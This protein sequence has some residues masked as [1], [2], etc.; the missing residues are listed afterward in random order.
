M[1]RLILSLAILATIFPSCSKLNDGDSFTATSGGVQFRYEVIVSRMNF[2]RV[3]PAVNPSSL[4]GK[5]TIPSKVDYDGTT[6]AVTQV[7]SRAFEGAALITAITLPSGLSVIEDHAFSGCSSLTEINTPQPLSVIGEYA[8]EG[9]ANL[10]SF[11]FEA[12]LS[13]IGRG[14]FK[15]CASLTSLNLTSSFTSIADE[16][17]FGCASLK[18][19]ELPATIMQIGADAF[20]ECR[21]LQDIVLDRSVQSIGAEAFAGNSN[22]KSITCMTPTPPSCGESAFDGIP[23]DISVIVPIASVTSYKEASGWN[24]FLNYT[25]KY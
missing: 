3:S 21:D 25:G 17:F 4:T 14:A 11:N 24:R 5:V 18:S 12:S 20:G 23:V 7:A 1:K 9:C 6:Y 15:G 8:F 13:E 16:T 19:I 2:V 10:E 22:V